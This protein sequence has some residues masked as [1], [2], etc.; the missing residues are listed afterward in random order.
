[1][2]MRFGFYI[3]VTCVVTALVSIAPSPSVAGNAD[4]THPFVIACERNGAWH[5]AY[6]DQIAA[7]G[8]ARYMTPSG[9]VVLATADG[10]L[11]RGG[12]AV[13]GTCAGKTLEEM[14]APGHS[15]SFK[16]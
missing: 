16:E 2:M 11:A 7:D 3:G 9:K 12:Q 8:I 4:I 6:L 15:F 10:V 5:F 13:Q 1:M 14:R